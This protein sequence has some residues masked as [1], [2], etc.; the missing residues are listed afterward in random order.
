MEIFSIR[1]GKAESFN[2]P[3]FSATRATAQ[4][5]VSAGLKP[6]DP[7]YRFASDFAIYHLGTFETS[8]GRITLNE[9]PSHLIDV[10]ELLQ[11]L[12]APNVENL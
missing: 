3:F 2:R 11:I 7:M 6:D 1:D 12:E 8:S 9:Q 10:N 5:E 4:R